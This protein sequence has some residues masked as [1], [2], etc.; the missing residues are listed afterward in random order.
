MWPGV[1]MRLYTEVCSVSPRFRVR[2][3]SSVGFMY[4]QLLDTFIF[5]FFFLGGGWMGEG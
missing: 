4:K 1:A 3:A 5:V 2:G